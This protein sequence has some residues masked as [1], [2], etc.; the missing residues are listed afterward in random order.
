MSR[1]L[2]LAGVLAVVSSPAPAAE[3]RPMTVDDLFRFR[4]VADP[5]IS[6]ETR[7]AKARIEVQN[8]HREL[9]LGMYAEALFSGGGGASMPMVPRAAVQNVGD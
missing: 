1:A 6:P 5:Q 3:K 9:R 7:T 4:R 2:L 8:P